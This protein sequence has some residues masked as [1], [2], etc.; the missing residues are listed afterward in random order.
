ME[1]PI[2]KDRTYSVEIGKVKV[3]VPLDANSCLLCAN[4]LQ[5][6]AVGA[7]D[8]RV[9]CYICMLRLRWILKK[10]ACPL[11][12][13]P[14]ETLFVVNT[15]DA[16]YEDLMKNKS[17]LVQDSSDPNVYY[18]DEVACDRMRK[19][20]GYYC[21][22]EG[23]GKN[24]Y[25]QKALDGHLR[26]AHNRVLCE[27]CFKNRPVFMGEQLVFPSHKLQEHMKYG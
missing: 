7:C 11:C 19:L 17:S 26:S 21:L 4:P 20:R 25:D 22:W 6:I 14:L 18:E 16:K 2:T 3:E 12:K 15:L 8:H 23:C 27:V 1:R 13:V 9:I 10:N 5:T 24:L